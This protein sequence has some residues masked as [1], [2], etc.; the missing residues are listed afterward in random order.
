MAVNDDVRVEPAIVT[1]HNVFAQDTI[2]ADLAIPAD[3]RFGMNDCGRMN[4]RIYDSG[5]TIYDS[6]NEPG[7]SFGVAAQKA[8]PSHLL[9]HDPHPFPLPHWGRGWPEAG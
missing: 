3:L 5:F 2:R 4:H 9:S 1:E 6:S 8:H 7:I